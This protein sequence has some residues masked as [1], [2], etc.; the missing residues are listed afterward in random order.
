PDGLAKSS[1]NSYLSATQRKNAIALYQCLEETRKK[2]AGGRL[3]TQSLLQEAKDKI[4]AVP[5]A[6]IDY[7]SIV[8]PDTL[9]DVARVQKPSLMAMAVFVGKTRLIDNIMLNPPG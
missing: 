6:A 5:E 9:V 3:D 2:V 8:D 1:R 4:A 7:I